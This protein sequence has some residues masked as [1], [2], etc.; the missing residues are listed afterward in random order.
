MFPNHV[1]AQVLEDLEIVHHSLKVGRRVQ[2]IWPVSLV[3]GAKLK[4][5][6]AV[7]EVT[8]NT[9]H[10]ALGH[11][12][13]SSVAVYAVVVAELDHKIIKGRR[14]WPPER[15]AGNRKGELFVSNASSRRDFRAI[16]GDDGDCNL[17]PCLG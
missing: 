15:G 5:E 11:S 8:N 9:I 2:A 6:F 1:E 16:F 17:C 13:E 4:D 12:T 14:I 3:K 10:F 7:E